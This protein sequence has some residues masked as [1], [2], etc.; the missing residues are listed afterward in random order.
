MVR[1]GRKRACNSRMTVQR[2]QGGT[3][4]VSKMSWARAGSRSR[5]AV[6][7][8]G[9]CDVA[10]LDGAAGRVGGAAAAGGRR[11]LDDQ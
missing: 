6:E 10:P 1:R 9:A 8:L 4:R 2:K 7:H 11:A 5:G 3:E